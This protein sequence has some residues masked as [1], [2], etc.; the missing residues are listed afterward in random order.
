MKIAVSAQGRE[1]NSPVDPRFGRAA[2]FVILDS[3]TGE[4]TN[5]LD[6]RAAQDA[7][8]GAGINAATVVAESGAQAVLTGRVG[9]KAFTVLDAAGIK[10]ISDV[11]GTVEDA[12]ARFRSGSVRHDSGPTADGHAPVEPQPPAGAP[13]GAGRGRC[14][15]AGMGR[16]GGAGMGGGGRGRG[17]CGCGGRGRR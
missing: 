7:P 11:A 16:G 17:G 15:G 9:P 8:H 13:A 12:L 4:I 2:W 14:G 10:V 5:V 6:N 3:D 1:K